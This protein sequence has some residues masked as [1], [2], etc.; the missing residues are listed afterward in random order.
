MHLFIKCLLCPCFLAL[1]TQQQI[2]VCDIQ[3]L[4]IYMVETSNKQ[5]N[6]CTY[7]IVGYD[8]FCE[9]LK[10]EIIVQEV[11]DKDSSNF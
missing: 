9:V 4:K 7:N 2:K 5:I 3:E 11:F 6:K 10:Q 8:T 1:E